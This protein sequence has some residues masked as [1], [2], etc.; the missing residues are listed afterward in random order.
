[1]WQAVTCTPFGVLHTGSLQQTQSFSAHLGAAIASLRQL[2]CPQWFLPQI[3]VPGAVSQ[4]ASFL[5]VDAQ[6]MFHEH[7]SFHRPHIPHCKLVFEC[8][9]HGVW[10][11][12][13]TVS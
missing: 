12:L 1:M 8:C 9:P 6:L 3:A 11:E 10:L 5:E 4:V 7:N 2:A 13:S